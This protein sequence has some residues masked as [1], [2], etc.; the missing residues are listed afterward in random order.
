MINI[1]AKQGTKTDNQHQKNIK[2]GNKSTHLKIL[3]LS[4]PIK[5][6]KH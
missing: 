4:N 5:L 1:I 2:K 3:D 6:K